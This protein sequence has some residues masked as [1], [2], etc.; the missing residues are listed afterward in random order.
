MDITRSAWCLAYSR[1]SIN[2][3][4]GIE[5]GSPALGGQGATGNSPTCSKGCQVPTPYPC[6]RLRKTAA[7]RREPRDAGRCWGY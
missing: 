4:Q 5:P 2:G 3:G 6:W 1:C 7:A